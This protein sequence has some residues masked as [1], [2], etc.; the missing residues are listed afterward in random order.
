MSLVCAKETDPTNS[1]L[2]LLNQEKPF[3]TMEKSNVRMKA[4]IDDSKSLKIQW[5]YEK[6]ILLMFDSQPLVKALAK[7]KNLKLKFRDRKGKSELDFSLV[8]FDEAIKKMEIFCG[9]RFFTD[10]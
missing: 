3:E 4:L 8:G 2:L 6:D 9:Y 1:F 10:E 5:H 7:G